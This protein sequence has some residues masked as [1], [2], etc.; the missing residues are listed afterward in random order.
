MPQAPDT[1]RGGRKAEN[2]LEKLWRFKH[3]QEANIFQN[4]MAAHRAVQSGALEPPLELGPNTKAWTD[5]MIQRYLE[6]RPRRVPAP[7]GTGR[8]IGKKAPKPEAAASL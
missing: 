2:A 1:G 6:S 7:P 5:G 8:K 4:R 3:L